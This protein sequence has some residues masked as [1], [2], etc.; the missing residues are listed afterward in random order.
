MP[1]LMLPP[2]FV[3]LLAAF[4]DCFTAPSDANFCRIVA[5]WAHCLGRRT[6]TAVAL[7]SG[8]VGS[9]HISVFHRF[10]A[11]D[12][13]GLVADW[14]GERTVYV[15]A[16]SPY[17]GRPLLE[18]RPANVHMLSRLRPDAALWTQP[19][20]RRR[21]VPTS[22]AGSMPSPCRRCRRR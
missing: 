1:E 7:A 13:I 4:A 6:V 8:A 21:T 15:A 19:P 16:D 12:M 11:R 3:A 14:A 10:F 18:G 5:G 2:S 22:P 17:A 9:R 20:P